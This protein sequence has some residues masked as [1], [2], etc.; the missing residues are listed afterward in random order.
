MRFCYYHVI[1][2]AS[3]WVDTCRQSACTSANSVDS[4]IMA[5]IP[6][7]L[8]ANEVG[9]NLTRFVYLMRSIQGMFYNNYF[10][11]FWWISELTPSTEYRN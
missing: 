10:L 3:F 9:G 5:D 2:F 6:A 4:G 11:A 8:A 1:K 7:L